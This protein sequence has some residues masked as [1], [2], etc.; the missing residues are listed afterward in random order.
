MMKIAGCMISNRLTTIDFCNKWGSGWEGFA[1]YWTFDTHGNNQ[2]PNAITGRVYPCESLSE[3]NI[4]YESNNSSGVT[5]DV[6]QA[7]C[8]FS[9][10]IRW[11]GCW[12][13][14]FYFEDKELFSVEVKSLSEA[15]ER[16]EK[17]MTNELINAIPDKD[18]QKLMRDEA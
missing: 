5:E 16:V 14:R 12:S 1:V 10:S 17:V 7:R 11:R 2:H 9:F 15:W 6:Q 13:N 18:L 3:S 4:L 8:L